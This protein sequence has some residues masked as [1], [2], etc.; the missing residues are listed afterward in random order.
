[1]FDERVK[2]VRPHVLVDGPVAETGYVPAPPTK[3]AIVEH[4]SLGAYACCPFG[5]FEESF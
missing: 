2:S 3:P 5:E 1:V 4:E